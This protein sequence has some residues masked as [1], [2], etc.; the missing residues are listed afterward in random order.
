MKRDRVVGRD[1]S[2][3]VTGVQ[4]IISLCI[5]RKRV[6]P[7]STTVDGKCSRPQWRRPSEGTDRSEV[8]RGNM[9]VPGVQ[10]PQLFE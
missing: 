10:I 1:R 5:Y 6:F 9:R 4:V 7:K 2:H 3:V 8:V